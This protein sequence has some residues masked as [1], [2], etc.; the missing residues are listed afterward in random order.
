M[1]E[2]WTLIASSIQGAIRRGELHTGERLGS[3]TQ[4]ALEWKVSPVTIQKAL[5]TLQREGWVVRRPRIGTVVAD[6]S[7]SA[8][9]KVGLLV[10]GTSDL[11]Q[12]SYMVGI[13]ANL[14]EGLEPVT[15]VTENRARIE[16]ECLER[17]ASECGAL[18]CCPTGAPENTPLFKTIA[19]LRPTVLIDSVLDGVEA[20]SVMTDNAGSILLGLRHLESLGHSRIAYFMRHPQLTTSASER[21][22]GYYR[23]MKDSLG[24]VDPE[25]WVRRF[26]GIMSP[27]QHYVRIETVLAEMLRE[28][29]PVTAIACDQDS[30]MA[31]VLE[32]AIHLGI[33]LPRELEI[34]SFNDVPMMMQPLA[35][36]VHR[37]VPRPAA[38]GAMAAERMRLRLAQPTLPP[39]TTR[40]IADL[41]P[42]T[43]YQPGQAVKDF[44][45]ARLSLLGKK[46]STPHPNPL[47]GKE[48]EPEEQ[49]K[50]IY[51]Y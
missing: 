26:S 30:V 5:S 25:R 32:A 38:L 51:K 21:Y 18:I 35:R 10:T 41:Q 17:A 45:A 48:R 39:M 49:G 34:L 8:L 6:R 22:K 28:A 4:L 42:A 50:R 3:E 19:A 44:V 29:E 2:K 47:L 24:A 37:L 20:D 16:A 46:D 11:P 15:Y 9:A 23:Y 13:V 36:T 7:T 1:P 31:A 14:G 33:S 27:E 12:S 40:L 43:H